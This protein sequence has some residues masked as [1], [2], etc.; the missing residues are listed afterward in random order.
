MNF[1][2]NESEQ[3][4]RGGYYTPK[5]I[6]YF[7]TD[8]VCE[9]EDCRTVLEPSCGDGVFFEAV[10][11][12]SPLVALTGFEIDGKEAG[13]SIERCRKLNLNYEIYAKDF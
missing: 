12:Y 8:W 1:K 5:D 11:N 6:A 13:K 3:K 7:I 10:E 9:R 4:L 2:I